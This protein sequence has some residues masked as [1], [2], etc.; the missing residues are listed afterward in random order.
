MTAPVGKVIHR[1]RP[2]LQLVDAEAVRPC[3]V[4]RAVNLYSVTEYSRL[5]IGNILPER[6][7]RIS[8]DHYSLYLMF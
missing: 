2:H 1:R 5:T 7:K 4:V 6:K 3:P 8:H